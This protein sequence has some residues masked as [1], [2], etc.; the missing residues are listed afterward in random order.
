MFLPQRITLRQGPLAL[1]LFVLIAGSAGSNSIARSELSASTTSSY[2][3]QVQQVFIV[4][5][6]NHSYS[7]VIG[8][9]SMPYLNGLAHKYAY[10]DS[11]YANTHPSI[12]NYFELTTGQLIT[13]DDGY[14][15]TVTTD[16]IVRHL[17]TAGKTWMEYS[18]GSGVHFQCRSV[19]ADIPIYDDC[20]SRR[21]AHLCFPGM[22][23]GPG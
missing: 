2:G 15:Q 7:D 6:E 22:E 5:L 23:P 8:N 16:N 13:N 12:G 3:A 17:I 4:M 10:A 14:S 1:L 19:P 9:A 21:S 18:E 11:Y 20:A